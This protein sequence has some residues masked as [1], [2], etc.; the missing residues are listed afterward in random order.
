[1]EAIVPAIGVANKAFAAEIYLPLNVGGATTEG[2]LAWQLGIVFPGGIAAGPVYAKANVALLAIGVLAPPIDEGV[3]IG[4]GVANFPIELWHHIIYPTAAQPQEY[5]GVEVVVIGL[6]CLCVAAGG[7]LALIAPNTKGANAKFDPGL[8]GFDGPVEHNDDGIYIAAAPLV[9]A[10]AMAIF[11]KAWLVGKLFA[12]NA[13]GV[14]IIVEMNAI[15]VVSFYKIFDDE[16][17]KA[18]GF[19]IAG[20]E[21]AGGF[22]GIAIIEKPLG[23]NAGGMV[24]G[25]AAAGSIEHG[26]VGVYPGMK[27]HAKLMGF[28]NHKLQG[29]V[30][31]CWGQALPAG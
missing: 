18:S 21:V 5:V 20:V 2:Y 28:G 10:E 4:L 9:F 14:K 7:V 6:A 30:K 24:G 26:P 12:C 29:I 23:V 11:G 27:L 3:V 22:C 25:Y 19:G 8:G 1:M 16:S 15:E 13:V 17:N 31:R